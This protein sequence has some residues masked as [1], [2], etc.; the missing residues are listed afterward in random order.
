M[1]RFLLIPALILILASHINSKPKDY[2]QECYNK[3]VAPLGALYAMLSYNENSNAFGHDYEPWK[4]SGFITKGTIW[5]GPEILLKSDT[6]TRGAKEYYSKTSFDKS[7][8][9]LQDYG[10]DGLYAVTE[11]MFANYILE[12]AR[13]TPALLIN[14]FHQQKASRE[15]LTVNTA[16]TAYA[17]Y[18]LVI[19][20]TVVRLFVNRKSGLLDKTVTLKNDDMLGDLESTYWYL[21]YSTSGNVLHPA[22]I[23]IDKVNGK[24]HDEIDV[25]SC[26]LSTEHP[27]LL[28]KPADYSL[29][30]TKE[31]VPEITTEKYNDNIYFVT[32]KHTESKSAIV[33]FKDF[34]LVAEAPLSS[35]NGE[36]ILTEA[37]KIAPGKPVKYFAF[38][39]HHPWYLGG[40]RPFIHNGT[41]ILSV[42]E[43][44]PYIE[45]L[46]SA[47]HTLQP[48]S[49][50]LHPAALKT[51]I[52]ESP[53]IITDGSCDISY[54]R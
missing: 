13:Y 14:Y 51:E 16:D 12:T 19:K 49:L 24:L 39:H 54:R 47:R 2:L 27:A 40:V 53:E 29:V 34:V 50:E 21:D 31:T 48:D 37:K 41:V 6:L 33:V 1:N 3:Q 32:L 20:N 5:Y 8:L 45:Y 4:Q 17:V 38:S 44:I 35:A 18:K 25:T 42:K 36:L 43:D 28:L 23:A 52:I 26:T 9:L 7:T 30:T 15:A 10:D 11:E 22:K 46:A